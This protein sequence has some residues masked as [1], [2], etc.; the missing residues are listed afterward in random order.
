MRVRFDLPGVRP[1]SIDL[2]VE[3][4]VLTV[5][6]RAGAGPRGRAARSCPGAHPAARS[7]ARCSWARRSTPTASRRPY[8]HGV[9]PSGPG[10]RAGQAPQGRGPLG[11]ASDRST[12]RLTL[13]PQRRSAPP[14]AGPVRVHV[15]CRAVTDPRPSSGGIT[16]TLLPPQLVALDRRRARLRGR[17][18]STGSGPIVRSG[19]RS[20]STP[21]TCRRSSCSATVGSFST[22]VGR[23]SGFLIALV[24]LACIAAALA[25]PTDGPRPARRARSRS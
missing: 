3:R 18:G 24:G 1:D 22:G 10:R 23:R 4:N 14:P 25:R 19:R 5:K 8:D 6:A 21:T 2:T 17:R 11:R 20:G 9:L 16:I 15:R 7:P 12:R 13:P